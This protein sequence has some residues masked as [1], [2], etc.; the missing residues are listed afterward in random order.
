MDGHTSCCLTCMLE[1]L[2]DLMMLPALQLERGVAAG[3]GVVKLKNGDLRPNPK[4][5]KSPEY[6]GVMPMEDK[7]VRLFTSLFGNVN[8]HGGVAEKLGD[9]SIVNMLSSADV[10]VL[11]ETWLSEHSANRTS[12]PGYVVHHCCGVKRKPR[13]RT[14]GGVSVFVKS[15]LHT[16]VTLEHTTNSP[17]CTTTNNKR[18]LTPK[19]MP[20]AGDPAVLCGL[21]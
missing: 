16:K 11:T 12:L 21:M 20:P 10:M 4:S 17:C 14:P 3:G 18:P 1:G 13:G 2:V 19:S 6:L 8:V 9:L 7:W 5:C 15:G